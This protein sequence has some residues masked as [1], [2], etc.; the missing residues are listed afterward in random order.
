MIFRKIFYTG[1]KMSAES[2]DLAWIMVEDIKKA[3]EFYT[4]VIG[5]KLVEFNEQYG[6]AE[7]S[8]QKGGA[9][10]GIGQKQA[11][12]DP[13]CPYTGSNAVMTFTVKDLDKAVEGLVEKGAKLCGEIVTVPGHVRMQS[14]SDIDGNQLQLVEVVQQKM[15]TGGCCGGH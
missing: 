5:L 2:F 9:R 11:Q 3:I 7:L 4:N 6:W 10:L 1:F 8:G 12:E 14:V 13:S 15:H